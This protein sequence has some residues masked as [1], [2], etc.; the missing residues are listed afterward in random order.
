[1][2]VGSALTGPVTNK[3]HPSRREWDIETGF[4]RSEDTAVIGDVRKVDP[5][6]LRERH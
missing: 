5:T 3:E 2:R 4:Y 1:M 6:G